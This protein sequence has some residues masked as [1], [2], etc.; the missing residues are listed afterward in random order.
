MVI[1]KEKKKSC[2]WE[3]REGQAKHTANAGNEGKESSCI[4]MRTLI[5]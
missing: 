3:I 4:C 2:E 5:W 1:K